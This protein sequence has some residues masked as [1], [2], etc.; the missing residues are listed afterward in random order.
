MGFS[1]DAPFV[2][3]VVDSCGTNET[4]VVCV[5]LRWSAHSSQL[6][7]RS[8]VWQLQG[9][10]GG[11]TLDDVASSEFKTLAWS[12]EPF[13]LAPI[14]R[15]TPHH[16]RLAARS[17]TGHSP[18]STWSEQLSVNA[19]QPPQ[20]PPPTLAFR[21]T[22]HLGVRWNRAWAS[23]DAGLPVLL[24]ELQVSA[25]RT[26]PWRAAYGGNGNGALLHG[27]KPGQEMRMQLRCANLLG[28][29][30]WSEVRSY[31]AET[32]LPPP[33]D[34]PFVLRQESSSLSLGW[35]EPEETGGEP[36][37]EYVL[38]SQS[39]TAPALGCNQSN[40]GAQRARLGDPNGSAGNG[41][42]GNGSEW[43]AVWS[44]PASAPNMLHTMTGLLPGASYALRLRSRSHA[45][46][47]APGVPLSVRVPLE[48]N[49]ANHRAGSGGSGGAGS[50]GGSGAGSSGAGSSAA[51]QVPPSSS[52]PAASAL[53]EEASASEASASHEG[54][55]SQ[56]EASPQ[57]E[58]Q[59]VAQRVAPHGLSATSHPLQP[60]QGPTELVHLVQLETAARDAAAS[61]TPSAA[62]VSPLPRWLR[63]A[64]A[65]P[66]P[67]QPELVE[68]LVKQVRDLKEQQAATE[69]H[70]QQVLQ[71]QHSRLAPPPL[72]P[73]ASPPPPPPSPTPPSPPP[74]P[75]LLPPPPPPP[76][77]PPLLSPSPP[78]P[79]PP[80]PPLSSPLSP[81]ESPASSPPPPPSPPPP[82]L[83]ST[84]NR[85]GGTRFLY[86]HIPAAA[87]ATLATT[88]ASDAAVTTCAP[89]PGRGMTPVQ[90]GLGPQIWAS[91]D[92]AAEQQPCCAASGLVDEWEVALATADSCL[93]VGREACDGCFPGENGLWELSY[94][95][96]AAATT[97]SSLHGQ[98]LLVSTAF[99]SR[100]RCRGSGARKSQWSEPFLLTSSQAP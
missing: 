16:F 10:S 98:P 84:V 68:Q 79:S 36:L 90:H 6:K 100:L 60:E 56:V 35:H 61:T 59:P 94:R 54:G 62:S 45:G 11:D 15:N 42:A 33:P 51:A 63:R 28:P 44:G 78:P 48:D 3:D 74:P 64:L 77:P 40:Q 53:S 25:G 91:W 83:A 23:S 4:D 49:S 82:L 67:A 12:R 1:P 87:P 72:P 39:L 18:L 34:R 46:L 50:S 97:V 20:P 30:P 29:S 5:V 37:L 22:S 31:S 47:S 69:Q 55:P 57:V 99:C 8:A 32:A 93:M 75:P 89:S 70:L 73:L 95:G 92:I 13:Y 38:E 65:G 21:N 76:P 17:E 41:S 9:A 81:R 66:K 19:S 52:A 85:D 26:G 71:Q 80:P 96:P 43:R 58:A 14:R 88:S 86:D 24:C 7:N 27:L 2:S